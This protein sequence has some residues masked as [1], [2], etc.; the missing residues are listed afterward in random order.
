MKRLVLL[1][2]VILPLCFS[3]NLQAQ[4]DYSPWTASLSTNA[5]NNPVRSLPGDEGRFKTWNW[6][7]AGFKI[8]LARHIKGNL[9][10]ETTISLS[11]IKQNYVNLDEKFPL[12]SLDGLFKLNLSNSFVVNPYLALGGGY[13]W[14]DNVGAG[15]LNAGVGINVWLTYNFG[16]TAQSVYKHTFKDYGL[17]HYQHSVGII[18]KFGGTDS[19]NDGIINEEDQ[20]PN[21]FG[22]ATLNGCPD[23]DKDGIADKDD[24]CPDMPG[25]LEGCPDTDNDGVPDPYDRC[26][27]VAGEQSNRGCPLPDTDGDGVLDKMDK[28]PQNKGLS[29]NNGCPEAKKEPTKMTVSNKPVLIYF[30]LSKA[31]ITEDSQTILDNVAQFMKKS[32]FKSYEISGHTDNTSSNET[33]L[34]L[35]LERANAVRAYLVDKG[36]DVT[37]LITK[38]FGEE[39]PIDKT[40]TEE[41][42]QK[43]RRVEIIPLQ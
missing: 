37:M 4:D 34:K 39:F 15:T 19:D 28:C 11:G 31:E 41:G 7:P 12:I 8:G 35:S 3:H 17:K 14:L 21:V 1:L 5:I 32:K 2:T 36:V 27:N 25:T 23:K 20:C 43:N 13:T 33:N 38:G 18:F 22:L 29:S 16:L 30:E 40:N 9:S 6:D 24:N 10:F 26:P 42:R